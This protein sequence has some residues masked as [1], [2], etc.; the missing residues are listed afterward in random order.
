MYY[1][2]RKI[3]NMSEKRVKNP[4]SIKLPYFAKR[5]FAT[6]PPPLRGWFLPISGCTESSVLLSWSFANSKGF[7]RFGPASCLDSR[8]SAEIIELYI[9]NL[10]RASCKSQTAC[11]KLSEIQQDE[12]PNVTQM[13]HKKG[14]IR[15]N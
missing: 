2:I 4:Y 9:A 14:Q 1:A 13:P 7:W 8:D 6:V 11:T 15:A 5:I 3:K 10:R 12:R